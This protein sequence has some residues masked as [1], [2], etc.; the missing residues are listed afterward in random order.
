MS[1]WN[2]FHAIAD[3]LIY[4]KVQKTQKEISSLKNAEQIKSAQQMQLGYAKNFIFDVSSKLRLAD[5]QVELYPLQAHIAAKYLHTKLV[6]SGLS[7]SDLGEFDD[8]EFFFQTQKKIFEVIN[9]SKEKLTSEQVEQSEIAIKYISEMPLLQQAISAITTDESL[10]ETD[11]EWNDVQTVNKRYRKFIPFGISGLIIVLI[12]W[13]S[14]AVIPHQLWL[15]F[16]TP[17][18]LFD[19]LLLAFII[20]LVSLVLIIYGNKSAPGFSR[21]KY[22]RETLQS[23]LLP[24]NEWKIIVSALGNLTSDEYKKLYADRTSF[25]NHLMKD[26]VQ[27]YLIS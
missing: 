17:Y 11:D 15:L 26:E 4:R 1:A 22:Q 2:W 24:K 7:P 27:K 13:F 23:Q 9:R 21:L 18:G 8:M 12:I 19:I 25:L 10:H 3:I 20:F 6:N 14:R 5:E 16:R